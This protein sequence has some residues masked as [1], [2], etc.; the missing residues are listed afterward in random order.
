MKLLTIALVLSL[1]G[2]SSSTPFVAKEYVWI[3]KEDGIAMKAPI[4]Y[5]VR[6]RWS[7]DTLYWSQQAEDANGVTDI[8]SETEAVSS[9]LFPCKYFDAENW[10]CAFIGLGDGR[11]LVKKEMKDGTLTWYYW[12]EQRRMEPR[13]LIWNKPLPF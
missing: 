4:T 3:Q 5:R 7:K 6:V 11:V 13:H 2:C 12:G 10:S 8:I 9:T 1:G